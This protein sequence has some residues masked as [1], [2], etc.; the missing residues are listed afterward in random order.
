MMSEESD[1][2]RRLGNCI[3]EIERNRIE[4]M[5]DYLSEKPDREAINSYLASY[6]ETKKAGEI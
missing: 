4:H 5:A 6:R 1:L 3:R 2:I